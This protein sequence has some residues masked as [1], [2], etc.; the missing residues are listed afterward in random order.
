[1]RML[2]FTLV[3]LGW[4]SPPQY[5]KGETTKT[6][7]KKKSFYYTCPM[8]P[9]VH[10]DHPGNCPIC[11]MTLVKKYTDTNQP[12][13]STSLDVSQ[14]EGRKNIQIDQNTFSASGAKL[15]KVEKK[16]T[17]FI[18]RAFGKTLSSSRF[19]LQIA[20]VDLPFITNGLSVKL[21]SSSANFNEYLGKITSIDS[22]LEP[23]GKTVRV[24]GTLFGTHS[25]RP[26]S[27]L[28]ASIEIP[29]NNI[30]SIPE[31]ALLHS[32]TTDYVFTYDEKK[33][34]LNPIRVQIGVSNNGEVEILNGL[35]PG[36]IITRGANFL[37]DSESR[38]Q[39]SY[40]QKNN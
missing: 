28:L 3:I 27:T 6:E 14:V 19:S 16:N 39:F 10:S 33:S 13:A 25:L 37:L 36:M 34:S 1:M 32:S 5:A 29:K 35:K 11:H 30:I 12:T 20:E 18:I 21:K 9:F 38:M 31:D 15:Y 7:M 40:D 26:E 22:Y 17:T 8:H 2:L 23:M 4:Y 24:E